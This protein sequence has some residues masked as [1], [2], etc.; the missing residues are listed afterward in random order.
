[1]AITNEVLSEVISYCE[2]CDCYEYQGFIVWEGFFF[3]DGKPKLNQALSVTASFNYLHAIS[4]D[5][6]LKPGCVWKSQ[7]PPMKH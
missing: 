5:I 2:R 1:M 6:S 7:C 3:K 4:C